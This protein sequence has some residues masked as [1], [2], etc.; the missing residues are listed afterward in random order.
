MLTAAAAHDGSAEVSAPSGVVTGTS[1]EGS[2]W[3]APLLLLMLPGGIAV[4]IET[5]RIALRRAPVPGFGSHTMLSGL[6]AGQRHGAP[7][8]WLYWRKEMRFAANQNKRAI[9]QLRD[10]M[11]LRHKGSH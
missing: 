11:K 8:M 6:S 3:A 1:G 2:L 4:L 9:E 5:A 10:L 7:N